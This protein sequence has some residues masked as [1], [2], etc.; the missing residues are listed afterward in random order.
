MAE[1]SCRG[2]PCVRQSGAGAVSP[3]PLANPGHHCAPLALV[4][5]SLGRMS[6]R[7][8]RATH[9]PVDVLGDAL[10]D[11]RTVPRRPHEGGGGHSEQPNVFYVGVEQRR[12]VE[13]D[14]LRPHVEAD[15]RRPA[16]R[17]DRR[18]RRRAVEPERDLRRQRRGA[19]AARPLDRRRRLQVDRRRQDVDAPRPARR[20]ADPADRRRPAR[21]RPPVRRGARPPVRAERRARRLP[22]D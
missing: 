12:R 1:I 3:L 21:S 22:L 17:L 8:G 20:P 5:R 2:E 15:L 9:R 7:A 16:D 11:D 6:H 19:A 13:D 18:D 4:V 14:R 10:A